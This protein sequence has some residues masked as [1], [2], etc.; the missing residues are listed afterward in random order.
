MKYLT[1][2]IPFV[3]LICSCGKEENRKD[4]SLPLNG[5]YGGTFQRQTNGNAEKVVNVTL[6][7]AGED[8]NGQG[9]EGHYP[10]MCNGKFE[11]SE[12]N[13]HFHNA[14]GFTTDFDGR[15]ILDG[16]YEIYMV[17]DHLIITRSY[18]NRVKDIYNLQ[19]VVTF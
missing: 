4:I 16:S 9:G 17:D 13:I 6:Y 11:V 12:G 7:F 14:C 3:L 2:F 1:Y 18:E 15:L 19:Q 5:T 10:A 8:F